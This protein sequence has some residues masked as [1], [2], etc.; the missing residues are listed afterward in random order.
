[1][2]WYPWMPIIYILAYAFVS[3]SIMIKDLQAAAVGL[4]MFAAFYPLY[5]LSR[6]GKKAT[7]KS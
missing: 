7:G 3:V 1:M 2:K 6:R 4:S 5:L